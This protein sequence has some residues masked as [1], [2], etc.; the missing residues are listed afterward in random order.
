MCAFELLVLG[1]SKWCDVFNEDEWLSFE[2]ARDILHYYRAGPG[3]P[4][5]VTMGLLWL[6]ATADL[7]RQTD[8]GP[9]FFALCA[10]FSIRCSAN[11]C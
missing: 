8:T 2:Y 6:E 7:L 11:T 4:Y 10:S 9:F 5:A 1:E 3:N